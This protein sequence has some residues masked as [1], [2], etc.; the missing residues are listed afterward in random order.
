MKN[1][2]KKTLLASLVV[3]FAMGVQTASAALIT[4]WGYDVNNTFSNAVAGGGTEGGI[5]VSDEGRKLSWGSAT[6]KSSVSV[7]DVSAESGLITNGGYVSGGTIT[8]DNQSI[9]LRFNTLQSFD[10]NSQLTL[11]PTVPAGDALSP[12]NTLFSGFFKETPNN[13]NCL[14]SS[15]SN[16]DDIF[17]VGNLES[18]GATQTEAGYEFATTFAVDD[19]SYTVFLELVGLT[20]LDNESCAAAGAAEGCV[21]LLTQENRSNSFDTRFRITSAPVSVPEP[22]TLALLGMGLAG[23]G[24]SRRKK[25]A[26][27]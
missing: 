8:H 10:L 6:R 27:A 11:T 5:T 4:D 16:C 12:V 9:L 20:A 2:I 22:G 17:T 25:A 18:L 26:K 7:T 24:L 23:I 15:L 1:V 14:E 3:P 13:G 19:Y 21:G